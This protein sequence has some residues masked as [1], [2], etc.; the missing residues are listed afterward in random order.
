MPVPSVPLGMDAPTPGSPEKRAVRSM[1]DRIAPRY[2][3]LNRVLSAGIDVRWRRRA[4]DALALRGSSRIL[5]VCTGTADLLV[6]SLLRDA[7]HHGTGL[8][9]SPRMLERGGA[10]L[11]RQG[12]RAR[13]RLACADAE[14]LPLPSGRFDAALVAFGI[15]NVGRP[16]AALRELRR[17][18]RP[19]GVLVILEF[20]M[21]EGLLGGLYRLYFGRVLP[22]VGGMVSGNRAA[23]SYLPASVARFPGPEAF[24]ALM[25]ECGY[26]EVSRTP[27]T[28]GIAQLYRGVAA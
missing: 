2:D 10:K 7:G 13:S 5:D 15:R 27:L 24:V 3:L 26:G 12:L 20:S 14:Q 6:E 11:E 17:A 23:Y 8:D 22:V 18:L 4:V 21:P 19:G 25:R 9:L 16:D 1:F 28:A